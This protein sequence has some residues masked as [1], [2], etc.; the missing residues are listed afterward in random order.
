[1]IKITF[2][3]DIMIE[4]P[5]LKAARRKNGTYDFDDIFAP[6]KGLLSE[7]DFLVGNLET[8]LAGA[9]SGYTDDYYIFNAPD[10]FA[11]AVKKAGFRMVSTANNHTFDRGYEGMERTI[12]VLDSKGIGHHGTFLPGT[13]RSEAFY[14]TVGDHRVAIIAYTYGVNRVKGKRY[15]TTGKYADTVNLLRPEKEGIYQPGVFRKPDRIDKLFKMFDAEKRGRIKK[16]LGLPHNY[17][18][19][20]DRLDKETMEPY[21]ERFQADIREAKENADLVIFY[22]HVGGQFNPRPGAISEYVMDKAL[23]AG[24][25]AIIASHSHI[26]QKARLRGDV[27]CL[28]S[29]GNYNMSPLS[30]LMLHE[31]LPDYGLAVHL[32]AEQGRIVR[33]TFSILKIVEIKGSQVC[34]WPV[35]EYAGKLTSGAQRETL[36]AHVRQIHKTVTGH[37]PQGEIIQREYL[38]E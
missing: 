14:A 33:T 17:P 30:S 2:V 29:L 20:D 6:A 7:A 31:Y 37:P 8:P 11:D 34:A 9:D 27:P 25:D 12:Q 32:Y 1:M 35:D 19:A 28:Y 10:S 4:P 16:A 24:A 22:P 36:E 5:V 26:V 23:E 13:Q 3:G 21:V 38:L 18:R 15:E